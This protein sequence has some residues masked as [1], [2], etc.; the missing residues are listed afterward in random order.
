MWWSKSQTDAE[1]RQQEI[2]SLEAKRDRLLTD[3]PKAFVRQRFVTTIM[4]MISVPYMWGLVLRI[5]AAV[6]DHKDI[7]P[8]GSPVAVLWCSLM[9]GLAIRDWFYSPPL[10]DH[11]AVSD[12]VG[13]EP[14]PR[15][16]QAEI[17]RL[18]QSA[19]DTGGE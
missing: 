9:I 16:L 5:A 7:D 6:Y 4:A 14:T 13:Y 12:R 18:R 10:S 11:W 2:A 17:D 15:E 19:P 1:R 3:A 8:Q